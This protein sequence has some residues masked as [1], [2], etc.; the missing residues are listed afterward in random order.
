MKRKRIIAGTI[1]IIAVLA[2]GILLDWV[3]MNSRYTYLTGTVTAYDIT[4][5]FGDGPITFEIDHKPVDIGGGFRLAAP[6]GHV[7]GPIQVGDKVKA[8]LLKTDTGVTVY[9]CDECYVQKD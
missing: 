2:A 8:K 4:P 9:E 3:R 7:Y 1:F 5:S 6:A